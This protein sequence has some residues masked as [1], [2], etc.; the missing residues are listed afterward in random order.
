LYDHY[1]LCGEEDE[2]ERL[3]ALLRHIVLKAGNEE[4]KKYV[5]EYLSE[6]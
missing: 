6:E 4:Y 5:E 3:A 2:S 1:K